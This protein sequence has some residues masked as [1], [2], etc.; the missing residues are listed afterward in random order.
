[1][2]IDEIKSEFDKICTLELKE[3]KVADTVYQAYAVDD[4]EKLFD[5][6]VDL[7]PD[8]PAIVDERL[9]YWGKVWPSS[10]AMAEYLQ[11]ADWISSDMS[12]LELG[13]GPGIAGLGATN[14]TTEIT[15]SDYEQEA[16]DLAELNWLHSVGKSPKKLLLDWRDPQD[17]QF[18]VLLAADVAYEK[19]FFEPLINTFAKMTKKGGT[20]I[21]TEPGREIAKEFFVMLREQ[22]WKVEKSYFVE[23]GI[24]TIDIYRITI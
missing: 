11:L 16:L 2:R 17:F 24:Q 10:L 9:P 12:I 7:S 6:M 21:L 22:G 4:I 23:S 5:E 8:H 1:M 19:R 20:V 18:D 14:F 3:F 13:C 15:V